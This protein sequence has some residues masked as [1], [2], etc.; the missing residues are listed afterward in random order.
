M[1]EL[2][3]HH[4]RKRKFVKTCSVCQNLFATTNPRHRTC[5]SFECRREQRAIWMRQWWRKNPTY[6]K[7]WKERNPGKVRAESKRAYAKHKYEQR[8]RRKFWMLTTKKGQE[9][10]QRCMK[11]AD[12]YKHL[13]RTAGKILRQLVGEEKYSKLRISRPDRVLKQLVGEDRYFA[14]L[15]QVKARGVKPGDFRFSGREQQKGDTT[16]RAI[17]IDPEKQSIS[18]IQVESGFEN[19]QAAL[20][21]DCFTEG[22]YLS[23]SIE[24]G[25]DAVY[26]SDDELSE[27]D[28]PRFWFQVDAD[29]NPPSSFPIAGLGLALGTDTEGNG[30]DVR[31]SVAELTSRITFTQRKFHGFTVTEIPHGIKIEPNAPIIDGL[32]ED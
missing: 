7:D 19:I 1:M 8:R 24:K 5:G 16:M 12:K 13:C 31:I 3:R 6:K 21:C 28:N 26:A 23:G 10:H 25:F 15:R 29:R 20:R 30:C 27:E 2:K 14:I 22:A 32:T 18:E 17:L 9:Y 4:E 11:R